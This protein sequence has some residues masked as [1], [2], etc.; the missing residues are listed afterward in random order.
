MLD[1]FK[2]LFKKKPNVIPDRELSLAK[3]A[4]EARQV[5]D[6]MSRQ[7]MT[8]EEE[9]YTL[10]DANQKL[11]K[12]T[13]KLQNDAKLYHRSSGKSKD[14][15]ITDL[16]FVR[17][18]L[19]S[20]GIIQ[21]EALQP[22]TD[23]N[24]DLDI[25]Y[26][27]TAESLPPTKFLKGDAGYDLFVPVGQSYEIQ[28]LKRAMIDTGLK[29]SIPEGYYG[30]IVPRTST[31]LRNGL[32]I[33][34]EIVDSNFS[35]TIKIVVVNTDDARVINLSPGAR[36]A[37]MIIEKSRTVTW[38]ETKEKLTGRKKLIGSTGG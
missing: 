36:V 19:D 18:H 24:T 32:M 11:V 29:L 2:K 37:S 33:L 6:L 12:A 3:E 13:A 34:N 20:N 26:N 15:S 21:K 8:A 31:A 25:E 22:Y 28:P 7:L 23:M 9:L 30:R 17:K 4:K 35:D 16:K 10:R 1:W 27:K 38:K 14:I 5:A